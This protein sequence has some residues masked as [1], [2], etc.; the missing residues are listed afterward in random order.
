MPEDVSNRD[1]ER[2]LELYRQANPSK[3]IDE[4]HVYTDVLNDFLS[5]P[6]ALAEE[7][8]ELYTLVADIQGYD[9]VAGIYPKPERG[10]LAGILDKLGDL[11]GF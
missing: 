10:G 1:S 6:H 11:F 3:E 9:P 2:L 8:P 7:S 5:D 4:A